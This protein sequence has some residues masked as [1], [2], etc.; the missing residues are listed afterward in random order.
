MYCAFF[1][2]VVCALAL[3]Y[4]SHGLAQQPDQDFGSPRA[5]LGQS[6]GSQSGVFRPAASVT[7]PGADP[8]LRSTAAAPSLA[9]PGISLGKDYRVGPNDLLDIEILDLDNFK[10]TVRVNAAGAISLPLVG[11]VIV[12]GLTAQ[13]VE[14]NIAAKYSE[15]YLQNPQVSIFIKEFTTER[16]TVDGAVAKPGIYPLT[17]QITLLRAL[18]MAGGFGQIANST[19]VMLFRVNEKGERQVATFDVDLIRSGKS[20]DPAIKGDDLI[21]VQ[22][23]ATR[24]LLK[25]SVFRDIVDSINPF[26]VFGR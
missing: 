25:D 7:G 18:A 22:R 24:R 15:K 17:G 6:S 2:I 13:Q 14:I 11:P 8:D 19:E 9:I 20:E 12:A 3:G 21:V 26:S 1:H 16:I 10:R 23:D 4:S 5:S